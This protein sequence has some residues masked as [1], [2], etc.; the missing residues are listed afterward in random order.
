MDA[1]SFIMYLEILNV[2]S[3][4]LI[5]MQ[6]DKYVLCYRALLL[7]SS[8]QVQRDQKDKKYYENK[9][10]ATEFFRV[11]PKI[12]DLDKDLLYFVNYRRIRK[13]KR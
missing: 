1:L 6:S 5:T 11:L 3:S 10:W 2:S 4:I 12:Y 9:F 13:S 7:L 8:N